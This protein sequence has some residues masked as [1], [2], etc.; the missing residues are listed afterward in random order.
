[1]FQHGGKLTQVNG[2]AL[3]AL[4]PVQLRIVLA[5]ACRWRDGRGR[6]VDPPVGVVSLILA[7]GQY[8][9]I[10]EVDRVVTA[11]VLAADGSL[12]MRPG[13]HAASR[14]YYAPTDPSIVTIDV[15]D[16][17]SEE[18]V[19]EARKLLE[20]ELLGDFPFD[21]QASRANALSPRAGREHPRCPRPPGG[22]LL[23]VSRDPTPRAALRS[24]VTPSARMVASVQFAS[25]RVNERTSSPIRTGAD[26]ALW[27]VS[28]APDRA[29][30]GPGRAHG[31][32]II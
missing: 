1:V 29:A 9:G 26:G 14:L 21:G 19:Q 31:V 18:D 17:V 16:E 2:A 24:I 3:V 20:V 28:G 7:L 30:R 11:P 10:P 6:W 12:V 22:R 25:A 32:V 4:S 13:Y 5:Q 15:P 8:W 23:Q 27:N